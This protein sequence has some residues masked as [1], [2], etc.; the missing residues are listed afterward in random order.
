MYQAAP[1]KKK[2]NKPLRMLAAL[3]TGSEFIWENW[4]LEDRVDDLAKAGF[5]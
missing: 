5:D 1:F 4:N 2:N 3:V